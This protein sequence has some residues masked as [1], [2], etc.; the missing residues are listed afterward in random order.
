MSIRKTMPPAVVGHLE[1]VPPE[2]VYKILDDLPFA[3]ILQIATYNK[4]YLVDCI[5][6]HFQ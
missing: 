6:G 3:K 1:N 2:I 5:L 4:P